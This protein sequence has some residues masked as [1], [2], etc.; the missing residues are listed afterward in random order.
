VVSGSGSDAVSPAEPES[1]PE[2]EVFLSHQSLALR[3]YLLREV[4][5]Q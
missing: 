3:S 4:P 2:F 1:T 5:Q